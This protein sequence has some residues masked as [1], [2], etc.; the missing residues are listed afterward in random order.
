MI[1][2]LQ[3][4]LGFSMIGRRPTNQDALW[5]PVGRASSATRLF[6]VC[7]GLGGAD[8]GEVASR[9]LVD[10]FDRYVATWNNPVL[11][12][13]HLQ[14][15]LDMAYE[16]YAAFM[17][18][19]PTMSRMGTTLALL[20]LH[21]RGATLAHIGD[22]RIYWLRDGQVL[23]RTSDHKRVNEWVES[24]VLTPQQARN[25]PARNRLSRAVLMH[26]DQTG[27]HRATTQP[28][29][30]L[31]DDLRPGDSF[32]LCTDG[33]LDQLNEETLV[34]ILTTDATN[35]AKVE[36][37]LAACGERTQ[38]NY[39]AYLIQLETVESGAM[40]HPKIGLSASEIA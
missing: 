37:L 13:V 25:H 23:F 22:S 11:N 10:A 34:T 19:H 5:P 17:K 33:V 36:T 21:D 14:A 4:P 26:R 18:R 29:L 3:P 35:P 31:I 40:L 27:L 2:T 39:S 20:Q 32:F 30:L 7:D 24:G 12:S 6:V 16:A 1:Y 28:D 8:R 15:A 38:D 9:L